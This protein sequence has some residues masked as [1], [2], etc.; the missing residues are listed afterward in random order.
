MSLG[1]RD[2]KMA[3]QGQTMSPKLYEKQLLHERNQVTEL[4]ER[5]QQLQL[6]L[7]DLRGEMLSLYRRLDNCC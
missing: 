3:E 5:N 6:E 4:Q 7:L 2:V 1:R